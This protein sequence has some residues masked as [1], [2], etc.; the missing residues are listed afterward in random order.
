MLDDPVI[1]NTA[2]PNL[3][4]LSVNYPMLKLC[5]AIKTNV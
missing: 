5:N 2:F 1:V 3:K 4:I